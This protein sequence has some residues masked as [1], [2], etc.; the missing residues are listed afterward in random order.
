MAARSG[1]QCSAVEFGEGFWEEDAVLADEFSVEV[2]FSAA[3][4]LALDADHVPVDLGAV[5]VVGV[6]V[7]LAGGEVEGAGDFLVEEDVAHGLADVGVEAEGELADVACAGVAI[8]DLVD[9]PSFG[10]GFGLDDFSFLELEADGVEGDALIDG[11]GVVGDVAFDGVFDGG[12][13]DLSVRD[14]VVAAGG[15][16]GDAFDGEAEVGAGAGDVD[17]VG[18]FHELFEGVHGG[19]E[20]LVVEEADL[21]VEVLE[22]FGAH[23]GLLGHGG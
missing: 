21:E 4:V 1:L 17:L 13:E 15:E 22:G 3:V 6:L 23:A 10:S 12:G 18:G 7:G 2:D 9:F 11:G 20:G 5:A 16:G 19:D 8:E 14:V